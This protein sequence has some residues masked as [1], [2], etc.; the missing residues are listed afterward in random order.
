MYMNTKTEQSKIC[1]HCGKDFTINKEELSLYKKVD[2]ELPTLCFFCRVRLHFSFWMFGKFRKGKSDLSG[3]SL[4]TVLPEKN[5]YPIY[6]LHEWH[7]D[8]WDAMNYGIDYDSN[9]SFLK[10][11]QDLQEKVP[12][13]HQNGI[14]NTNCEWCDDVW[15]SRNCYLSRSMEECEYLYYSYRNIKVKNSIDMTV[16]FNSEKCFDCGD[17]HNSFKLFYSRHSRDCMDSYFLYDSRNCQDCFMC[18]NLR[19][20]RYC[21]ENVEYSKEEYDKKM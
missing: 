4:I 15:N 7:S 1:K 16:C 13:P 20:K 8:K 11:L 6:T 2:V 18:W 19:N 9:L 14:K 5:R 21:V 10:Q 12:K 17:C 3:E